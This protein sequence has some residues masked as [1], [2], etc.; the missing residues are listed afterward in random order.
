MESYIECKKKLYDVILEFLEESEEKSQQFEKLC[1][2]LRNCRVEE[3][4]EEMTQFLLT[5]KSISD[6]HHRNAHFIQKL[7]QILQHYKEQIK[8]TLSNDK[9][10]HIFESNKLILHFLLTNDIIC[11]SENIY[12]YM[13][14]ETEPNGNCYCHFFYP[15]LERFKGEE[16]MKE[17]KKDLLSLSPTIFENFEEKRQEGENDSYICSLIRNDS[18][19]DFIT[20]IIKKSISPSSQI[21]SS[22]FETNSFLNNNKSTS[23]IEYSAFFGSIQIFRFLLMNQVEL[24]PSLWLYSIHSKNADLI[25]LIESNR[26]ALPESKYGI[27]STCLIESIKCHHNDFSVYIQDSLMSQQETESKQT[28]ELLL[29]KSLKYHNYFYFQTDQI[30]EQGLLSLCF[31]NYYKIVDILMKE[32]EIEKRII[33]KIIVFCIIF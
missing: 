25:H 18:V 2:N 17:V 13:V 29:M 11:I 5:I 7:R 26:I 23:L 1:T 16:K 15:E 14:N 30:K 20:Y 27:Y 22:I 33:L 28:K 9:I 31:Y 3:D 6:H 24:K 10:F 19:E 21:P 4:R 12:N 32:K 8:Q